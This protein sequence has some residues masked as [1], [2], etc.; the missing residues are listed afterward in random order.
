MADPIS[1]SS[2]I[3]GLVLLLGGS[4][5]RCYQYGRT[6]ADAPK[7]VEL[8]ALRQGCAILPRELR[9]SPGITDKRDYVHSLGTAFLDAFRS[10]REVVEEMSIENFH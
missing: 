6:V 5:R 1:V 9:H 4:R 3:A 10:Q 7:E 8:V 2:S